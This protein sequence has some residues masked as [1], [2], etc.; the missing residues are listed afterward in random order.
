MSLAHAFSQHSVARAKNFLSRTRTHNS[1]GSRTRRC[2]HP[3]PARV[4]PSGVGN[5]RP[6]GRLRSSKHVG[7]G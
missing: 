7:A 1:A 5:V 4:N 2:G 3:Q 6:L